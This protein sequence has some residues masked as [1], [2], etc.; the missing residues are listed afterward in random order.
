MC[1]LS[2]T[3]PEPPADLA[4]TQHLALGSLARRRLSP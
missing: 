2:W 4:L 3:P 1:L